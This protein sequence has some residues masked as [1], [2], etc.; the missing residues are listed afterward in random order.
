MAFHSVGLANGSPR[1]LPVPVLS[2]KAQAPH[3]A[4]IV[5]GGRSTGLPQCSRRRGAWLLP[6]PRPVPSGM[7][8]TSMM[9]GSP[10][11]LHPR[12]VNH[13]AIAL[14]EKRRQ[15]YSG[16][17]TMVGSDKSGVDKDYG[18]RGD[19]TPRRRTGPEQGQNSGRRSLPKRFRDLESEKKTSQNNLLQR[20]M[21]LRVLR[22]LGNRH[23]QPRRHQPLA[24]RLRR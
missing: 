4:S 9:S 10:H 6:I 15:R 19:S 8:G 23:R 14:R 20:R 1:C 13:N 2:L 16:R 11:S 22:L 7:D 5:A 21:A 24:R 18:F 12:A 3:W 17:K